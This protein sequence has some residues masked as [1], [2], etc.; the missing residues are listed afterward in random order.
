VVVL[1]CV[2]GNMACAVRVCRI[3]LGEV[4]ESARFSEIA[5]RGG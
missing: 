5:F 2:C 1:L 3:E 4:G